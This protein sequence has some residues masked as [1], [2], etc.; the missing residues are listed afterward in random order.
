MKRSALAAALGLAATGCSTTP[1]VLPPDK[2]VAYVMVSRAQLT[3]LQDA[4]LFHRGRDVGT[5]AEIV[6]GPIYKYDTP[7]PI[8]AEVH[9]V[10]AADV[11]LSM[12][13]WTGFCAV[14]YSFTPRTGRT[15]RFAPSA[16]SESHCD[17]TVTDTQTGAP[18]EDLRREQEPKR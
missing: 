10:L 2:P 14:S 6:P 16:S 12:P 11:R 5:P 3:R 8:E 18:P 1:Y 7:H 9:S 4:K 13:N 15:Y 17:M